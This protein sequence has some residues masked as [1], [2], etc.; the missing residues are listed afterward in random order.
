MELAPE[1]YLA[2]KIS[3]QF[4]ATLTFKGAVPKEP[5]RNKML[6][7]WVRW[8]RHLEGNHGKSL[9][10]A[11]KKSAP[12]F[13]VREELGEITGRFHYHALLGGLSQNLVNI[14]TAMSSCAKWED[15]H[16]GMAR[17]YIYAPTLAGVEYV[18]KGLS[19]G[20]EESAKLGAIQYEMGKFQGDEGRRV[21]LGHSTVWKLLTRKSHKRQVKARDMRAALRGS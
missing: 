3:W 5:E 17:N 18:L 9:G 4:F 8:W 13:I 14:K 6:Y 2:Q 19:P 10:P 1:Q 7:A 12:L 20:R 15:L 11:E 21:L 16:G